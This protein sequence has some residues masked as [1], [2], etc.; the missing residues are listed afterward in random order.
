MGMDDWEEKMKKSVVL[1]LLMTMAMSFAFL[2]VGCEKSTYTD[3]QA[4][5]VKDWTEVKDV[6]VSASKELYSKVSTQWNSR[7]EISEE[8]YEEIR[9]SNQLVVNFQ[10]YEYSTGTTLGNTKTEIDKAKA[11]IGKY[12]ISLEGSNSHD[13]YRYY[14]QE[15]I[16]YV[17]SMYNIKLYS[18]DYMEIKLV[19]SYYGNIEKA[20][21]SEVV[22]HQGRNLGSGYIEYFI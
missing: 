13:A 19:N 12:Y 8:E 3:N 4:Y 2:F 20:G 9:Q 16:G 10:P 1:M 5:V 11:A 18:N 7:V 17:V 21:T 15:C 22:S 14:K 6:W